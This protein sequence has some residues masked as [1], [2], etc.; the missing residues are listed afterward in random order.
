MVLEKT[1]ES[2]AQQGESKSSILKEINPKYSL[3]RLVLKLKL[4]YF[5]HLVWRDNW[6]ENTLIWGKIGGKKRREWYNI[7]WLDGISDS[8]DMNLNTLREI[9][10]DWKPWHAEFMGS[11][12]DW[13]DLTTEQQQLFNQRGK[14]SHFQKQRSSYHIMDCIPIKIVLTFSV[15]TDFC[16]N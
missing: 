1:L 6:L 15:R 14:T 13:N 11:Q 16:K 5:S 10:K 7:R 9:M 2:L 8:M 4:Q 12:R 3:E